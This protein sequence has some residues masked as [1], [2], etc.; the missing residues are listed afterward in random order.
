MHLRPGLEPPPLHTSPTPPNQLQ[1]LPFPPR[2]QTANHAIKNKHKRHHRHHIRP[3]Q[4]TPIAPKP[5]PTPH[6]QQRK[7][8]QYSNYTA[9][10]AALEFDNRETR[11]IGE[12]VMQDAGGQRVGEVV[13][14]EGEEAE[15]FFILLLRAGYREQVARGTGRVDRGGYIV[16]VVALVAGFDP[17]WEMGVYIRH[18][19]VHPCSSSLPRCIS[20]PIHGPV[21]PRVPIPNEYVPTLTQFVEALVHFP[22]YVRRGTAGAGAEVDEGVFGDGGAEDGL[23]RAG[24]EG[25]GGGGLEDWRFVLPEECE[26]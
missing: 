11:G 2:S 5:P 16:Q 3:K 24:D 23:E 18:H 1:H 15:D 19:E 8:A 25:G 6:P 13:E 21:C 12:G 4:Q 7:N 20:I 17:F 9:H 22:F 26:T 14:S 10:I